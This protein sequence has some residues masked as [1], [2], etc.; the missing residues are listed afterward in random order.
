MV[1]AFIIYN[2]IDVICSALQTEFTVACRRQ[3]HLRE[4]AALLL[5]THIVY[6]LQYA[7]YYSPR[8]HV[9]SRHKKQ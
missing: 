1:N 7:P 4:R 9:T 8:I 6:I 5:D 2:D 3:E